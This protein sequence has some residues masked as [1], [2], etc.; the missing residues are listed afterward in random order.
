MKKPFISSDCLRLIQQIKDIFR[1]S[2]KNYGS[3]RVQ[4]TL[5]VKG[6]NVGRYKVR[7]LMKHGLIATWTKACIHT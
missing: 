5:I 6:M 3:L 1:N 2:L 7:K 4:Q